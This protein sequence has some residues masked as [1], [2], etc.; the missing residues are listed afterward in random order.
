VC[1][2]LEENR[3]RA[4]EEQWRASRAEDAS[5]TVLNLDGRHG[6]QLL[7][8]ALSGEPDRRPADAPAGG[9]RWDRQFALFADAVLAGR[10]SRPADA[11]AAVEEAVEVGALYPMGMNLGLRL[12]GEAALA[13]GW[14]APVDWL[15]AAEEYFHATDIPAVAS[16][17]RTLLRRCGVRVGQRRAG[18]DGIPPSLRAA[19]VTVREYEVLTLLGA[20]LGNR[21]IAQRL[22]LSV[23]TV[24]KHV[25][26]LIVKIGLPNRIALSAYVLDTE[27]AHPPLL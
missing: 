7:L 25:S 10:A 14:G 22:H 4:I 11:A 5:P 17:C 8:S 2:L 18:L 3:S 13:D 26:N 9:L 12:V 19:G 24:E 20:R 27:M 23:R 15:R 21:E 16:A 6:L 1:S